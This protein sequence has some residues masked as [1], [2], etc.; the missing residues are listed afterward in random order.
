[1]YR[2]PTIPDLLLELWRFLSVQH[3]LWLERRFAR[4]RQA[5]RRGCTA[6]GVRR[7]VGGHNL[8]LRNFEALLIHLLSRCEHDFANDGG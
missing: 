6:L 8:G 5:V 7:T 1:M 4:S 2:D 3:L